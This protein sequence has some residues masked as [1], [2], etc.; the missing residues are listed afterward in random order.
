V[1]FDFFYFNLKVKPLQLIRSFRLGPYSWHYFAFLQ[2]PHSLLSFVTLD[3]SSETLQISFTIPLLRYLNTLNH[4]CCALGH[5]P[6][7]LPSFH[8]LDYQGQQ[9]VA[10]LVRM[11]DV[12]QLQNFLVAISTAKVL[13]TFLLLSPTDFK[14]FFELVMVEVKVPPSS[15]LRDYYCLSFPLRG[16]LDSSNPQRYEQSCDR[17]IQAK[18]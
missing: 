14:I 6:N 3:A 15:L 16:Y 11:H 5:Y 12:L 8:H 9:L 18:C 7:H 13:V 10:I 4:C 2:L 17:Q 1:V